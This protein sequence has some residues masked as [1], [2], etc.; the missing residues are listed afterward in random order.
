MRQFWRAI[1]RYLISYC[2]LR[3]SSN[4]WSF[5]F[6]LR[7]LFTAFASWKLSPTFSNSPFP[8]VL[9]SLLPIYLFLVD[10]CLICTFLIW[11]LILPSSCSTFPCILVTRIWCL[12]K[13]TTPTWWVWVFSLP[14]YWMMYGYLIYWYLVDFLKFKA[15]LHSIRGYC[16]KM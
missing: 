5:D 10:H 1:K 15:V 11:L 16:C 4:Y 3:L 2:G 12:I 6:F 13:I 7:T 14:V 9:C 8:L